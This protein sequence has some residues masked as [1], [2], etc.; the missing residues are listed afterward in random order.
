MSSTLTNSLKRI[1]ACRTV[2]GILPTLFYHIFLAGRRVAAN[3]SFFFPREKDED[4]ILDAKR[5]IIYPS[6]KFLSSPHFLQIS[7]PLSLSF[8]LPQTRFRAASRSQ[9]LLSKTFSRT[10]TTPRTTSAAGRMSRTARGR[11]RRCVC[12][13]VCV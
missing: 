4:L 9:N 5:R 7:L 13:C 1:F 11:R 3:P 8:S 10:T 2:R 6:S 12:V